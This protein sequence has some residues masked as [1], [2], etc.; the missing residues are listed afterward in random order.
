MLSYYEPNFFEKF[1]W[2]SVFQIL[3]KIEMTQNK[4]LL[5]G[6][7]FEMIQH[8]KII[9][10]IMIFYSAYTY[11]ANFIAKF[12]WESGFLRGIPPTNGSKSTLKC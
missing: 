1:L 3:A 7:R 5:F 6:C 8:F 4:N 11:G 9:C 2:E 10:R 12:R